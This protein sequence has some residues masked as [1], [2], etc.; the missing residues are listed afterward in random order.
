[1]KRSILII[2]ILAVLIPASAFALTTKELAVSI[3]LA[4]K[5]RMLTQRM[6][7][8]ALLV[9]A[10]I[11]T[12]ENIEKLKKSRALFDKTLNGLIHGEKSLK[13]KPCQD[14]VVQVQ[15]KKVMKLW[16]S[17]DADIRKVIAGKADLNTYKRLEKQNLTLLKEMH[18]AVTMYVSE[19][20]EQTSKRAQAINLSGKERMLTQR[21][22]KDLLLISQGID[23]KANRADLKATA[24]EFETILRGLQK[25]DKKLGLTGTKLPAI[26]KQLKKGEKLWK[27]I[28]PAFATAVK[29]PKVLK[30]TIA[31]LD[32]LLIEMNKAVKK[33][34]K[35]IQREKQAL[36]LSSL[37]NNFMQTKNKENHLVNLSGKQ[38]MLTQK[39]T[40]LALLVSLNID[41]AENKKRLQKAYALYDKTL[42]G[43]AK[44]DISLDIE[45]TKDPKIIAY[46]K[47]VNSAWEP[48]AENIKKIIK[49]DKRD[50][51]A[52]AYVV[53][54]NESLLKKSHHLVQ[55]FKK[56]G[57]K[58]SFME[59][60]RLN[61]VDIAGRQRML[62]QKMTK[63]KLLILAK[64]AP[65]K[66]S[67][68]LH[69]S[70]AQFDK[71]LDVLMQGDTSLKIPKPANADIIAQLQKVD[72]IWEK[73]K[74]LYLKEKPGKKELSIIVKGNP[75]LLKEMNK[76]VHLSEVV[77]DY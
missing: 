74:P 23:T 19:T 4:G 37:V 43:F 58:K 45:A 38:R 40:K 17:F 11:D 35:S 14:P 9:K 7:K 41:K 49:S 56:S 12:K 10:G 63:E 69:E 20:K 68:K 15:L 64:V 47:E 27:D 60:A 39:M 61:I 76:A 54:H 75:V 21:M 26:K 59:K 57:G 46:L 34:E 33:F 67:N 24:S 13:L 2:W 32:I 77:V 30:K 31:K 25:G 16:N 1:M 66:N 70:V 71:A 22:A 55:L 48:F 73:L 18:K 3:N 5:Q 52:L 50:K 29:D 36:Q 42:K 6:T 65:Q 51:K 53:K 44:G 28:H 8:E 72:G 62:T